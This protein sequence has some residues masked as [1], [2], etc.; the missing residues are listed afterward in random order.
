MEWLDLEWLSATASFPVAAQAKA[1]KPAHL[2]SPAVRRPTGI[3]RCR[4]TMHGG[5]RIALVQRLQCFN[6]FVVGD[7]F[8]C[9]GIKAKGRNGL[10]G[11]YIGCPGGQNGP[12]FLVAD[13]VGGKH[14]TR[15]IEMFGR[16]KQVRRT[17]RCRCFLLNRIVC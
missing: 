8:I 7:G 5:S 4:R 9:A 2:R 17:D 12:L 14:I 1:A 3:E 10:D 16:M 13:A 6:D 11:K 15:V